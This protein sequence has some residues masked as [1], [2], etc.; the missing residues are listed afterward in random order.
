M[1]GSARA[2]LFLVALLLALA[3]TA[4]FMGWHLRDVR[5]YFP[6]VLFLTLGLLQARYSFTN[7]WL[8]GIL[9]LTFAGSIALPPD[10]SDDFQR[11]LWEGY[12]LT[13]GYSPYQQSPQ[14]LYGT[15]DHPSQGLINN[16]H[17]PAIYPPLAQYLFA[18]GSYIS[19]YVWGW[20]AIIIIWCL[21]WGLALDRFKSL[22]LVFS[23]SPIILIEGFWNAHLDILGILPC[24]FLIQA[25]EKQNSFKAGLAMGTIIALK[26]M[27]LIWFPFLFFHFKKQDR[28]TFLAST[29]GVVFLCYLPFLTQ[30]EQLFFSFITFSKTWYFNNLLYK[31]LIFLN[32]DLARPVMAGLFMASYCWVALSAKSFKEKCLWAWI[33]LIICSPT[34]FPWYMLWMIA[35]VS[36]KKMIRFNLAYLA[37][38]ISYWILVDYRTQGIWQEQ[39]A[40][41]LPEWILLS[42]CFCWLIR[43]VGGVRS[44]PSQ[45]YQTPQKD[46]HLPDNLKAT[47]VDILIPA[48]NEAEALPHLIAEIDRNLIRNILVVDNGSHDGTANIAQKLGCKV[49]K[50]PKPGYGRTCLKGITFLKEDPPDILVFLDGDRSDHPKFLP[51]LIAPIKADR[52]EMV[53]GSRTRGVSEKGSLTV[54][55]KFG[56][57]LATRLIR[58]FWGVSFTDLGPFRA[59]SWSALMRIQMED[60]TFG[61]TVEMQIKA[62]LYKL[63]SE[64]IAVDYRNRIGVSKIS[65]TISGVFRAGTKILYTV[66]RYKF[67]PPKLATSV[68]SQALRDLP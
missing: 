65:G 44:N 40:W 7:K 63:K 5:W 30:W 17:L 26:I 6:A 41:L 28:W 32:A 66:F 14:D 57:W 4:C 29:A 12:V 62:A 38:F 21:L 19:K 60:Q 54:T 68:Q 67:F 20:K 49:V 64:E 59:I 48:R 35:F 13:E 18:L 45:L 42:V 15:I 36:P 47:T 33:L 27:P 8:A 50:E 53:I 58:W 3:L 1:E 24:M 10:L 23:L 34:F 51:K 25:A 43:S 39:L 61:W 22:L 37:A 55:Q 56:N 46:F 9:V 11:Y 31:G 52:A 16:D 2:Q